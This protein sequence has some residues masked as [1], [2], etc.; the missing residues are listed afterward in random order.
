M[1]GVRYADIPTTA[2]RNI[3]RYNP[4]PKEKMEADTGA[5]QQRMRGTVGWD[6][7]VNVYDGERT[8]TVADKD[9]VDS[10][11]CAIVAEDADAAGLDIKDAFLMEN[12]AEPVYMVLDAKSFGE[13][14]LRELE[15]DNLVERGK[16]YMMV[17]GNMFG[18]PHA[19]RTFSEGRDKHL[20]A[21]G[22]VTDPSV[23]NLW[24][25]AADPDFAFVTIVDD[26]AIKVPKTKRHVYDRFVAA[27]A[28]KYTCT[29]QPE[30]SKFLGT[31]I[32][33][34]RVAGTI[35]ITA[36]NYVDK[37]AMQHADLKIT[38]QTTP[39]KYVA[40]LRGV[41]GPQQTKAAVDSPPLDADGKTKLQSIV[42]S[43]LWYGRMVDP[44]L[45]EAV[46]HLSSQQGAPTADT[47]QQARHLLGYATAY[48]DN[49]R[50]IRRSDMVLKC[51]SDA[52]HNS[53][54][55]GRSV[56]GGFYYAG[57]HGTD[58]PNA[59]LAPLSTI[60]DV[61]TPSAYESEVAA[62]FLNMQRGAFLRRIFELLGYPQGPTPIWTDNA[63][64]VSFADS[65]CKLSKSKSIDLRFYWIKDRVQQG[66]FK[67]KW[68]KGE[69]N[70]ADYF[71]KPLPAEAHTKWVRVLAHVPEGTGYKQV[72][73][74]RRSSTANRATR[75]HRFA[76]YGRRQSTI[77]H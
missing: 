1:H 40:P 57:D 56:A 29:H 53:R 55:K 12:L 7:R 30:L 6:K 42:G 74:K 54:T 28:A 49:G 58:T 14:V 44:T 38:P 32:K 66:Q 31:T 76:R 24:R 37:L 36:P 63:V 20:R 9:V 23:P 25:D 50:L 18:L 71:T 68:V 59:P 69:F 70:P 45:L 2:R 39:R 10:L 48:P 43:L 15:L 62:V 4:T 51:Y 8:A 72:T 41:T 21:H 34:D 60:I 33:R 5:F 46:G 26:F 22:Y 47:M 52:S 11:L 16:I 64:A 73:R 61:V 19:G 27:L 35:L 67:V 3:L 65:T 17:T 75:T 77:R 13:S